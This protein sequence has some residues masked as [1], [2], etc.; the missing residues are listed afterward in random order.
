MGRVAVAA[1][2]RTK[3][4]DAALRDALKR[5]IRRQQCD[6]IHFSKLSAAELANAIHLRPEILKP[7]L[8]TCNVAGRA[9]ARDLKLKVNTYRPRLTES[10]ALSLAEYIKP[11]LP[12]SVPVEGVV[13]IDKTEYIDKEI[14]KGKGAWERSVCDAFN[15]VAKVAFKKRK[16]TWGRD[17]FELDVASPLTGPIRFGV[18][19]KRVEGD[20]DVHKRSDEIVNKA[21]KFKQVYPKGKFAAVVYYPTSEPG[22][23]GTAAALKEH[24]RGGVRLRVGRIDPECCAESVVEV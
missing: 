22:E 4:V 2:T 10:Q 18:D 5:V 14:R 24:R 6:F 11:Y 7:L 17:N 23:H 9:I 1:N 8:V 21:D 12:D 16:F 13:L 19:V 3:A 20:L 15:E